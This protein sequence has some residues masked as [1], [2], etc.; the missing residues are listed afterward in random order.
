M[1]IARMSKV[2]IL[3]PRD[4]RE[5][6]VDRL[7]HLGAVHINDFAAAAT[8]DEELKWFHSHFEPDTRPLRLSIAKTEFIVELFERFE[9]AKGGL[10]SGLLKGQVHLTLEEFEEV[11]R[12]C[13]L[14]AAYGELE[15]L[16][17]RHRHAEN[18]ISDL[19]DDI[20][21]M[22]PWKALDCPLGEMAELE[23][24]RLRTAIVNAA[25]LAAWKEEMEERCPHTYWEEINRDRERVYV[26]AIVHLDDLPD[27]DVLSSEL[28]LEQVQLGG[29]KRTVEEEIV[30]AGEKLTAERERKQELEKR[31]KDL[32]P[33]KPKVLALYDYLHSQ[34]AKEE[35]KRRFLH[36][37][38]TIVVGGWVE[39][40]REAEVRE[41]LER[42]G[43]TLDVDFS[44]PG[45]E[46]LAPTLLVNRR[47]IRPA[48]TLIQLFGLPDRTETDPTPFVAPFFILFFGMCIGDVGY[49]LI[50]AGA[51]WLALKKL[52]VS[53]NVRRFLRLFMYC[54][55]VSIV[56]GILTAGY[57]GI[58][59]FRIAL[60][61]ENA[62]LPA[63]IK[64]P[65]TM[66]LLYKPIPFMIICLALGLIH[67]SIGVAI[68]MRDNMR[69]NSVWLG[70]CEQGTT[71]I[72]WFGIA[73]AAFGYGIK[74]R[75]IGLAGICIAGLGITGVIL[76]SNITSKSI[77]G[78]FFG[79][80]YNLYGLLASTI[81]D[82]ASYLRL[83]ALGLA[84]I[85]IAMVINIMAS[86][87][88]G[89]PL[90]GIIVL[91]VILLGGH[92][93]NLAVSFLSAFVH[94][95]R[96]QYVEFFSKFYEDGGEPFVPLAIETRKTVIDKE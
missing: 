39:E 17:V 69:H 63:Y 22:L 10:I 58:D 8:Q 7:Q 12:E 36:T 55:I 50:L 46:E 77:A 47:R 96:L 29:K 3:A 19:E 31:I 85:A 15:E 30:L 64:F 59:S 91:I 52:D 21:A 41:N 40:S 81:G 5:E 79:G 70:I 11:E 76:L 1:P 42:L 48:E 56:V 65:G 73:V 80:L 95:L 54:G 88:W 14:E 87:M 53:D 18:A 26:A 27:F 61:G 44:P 94:P 43:V 13:D 89:I 57:F 86:L 34:L 93:F 2:S 75:P 62:G 32:L 24:L 35:A 68:E 78:K 66:D 37:E 6:L 9:D 23:S 60:Y 92:A 16:D 4:T 28:D 20:A 83:Y 45:E 25:V 82:V 49:G 67:I 38:K 72:F 84:T 90:L 33:I 74:V 71:L 51:F